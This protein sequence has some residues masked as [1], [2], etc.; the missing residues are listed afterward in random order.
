MKY[1]GK[2]SVS[3][4]LKIILD[5]FWVFGWLAFIAVFIASI[6]PIFLNYKNLINTIFTAGIIII[7]LNIQFI[8]YQLREIT[9]TLIDNNPF[10]ISNVNKFRYIGYSVLFIGTFLLFKDIYL[11]GFHTL[12]IL[13]A[14][15]DGVKTNIQVYL[16]FILGIFSL[17]LS[18]IFKIAYK[19][20]EENKLT[21]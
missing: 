15:A 2:K 6:N 11:K 17:I 18:E 20:N 9:N 16:P 5:V 3:H 10:S 7:I 19:I 1:L 8:I 14:G 13:D 4:I 12:T 21:I